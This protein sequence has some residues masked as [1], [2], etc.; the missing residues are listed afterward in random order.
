MQGHWCSSEKNYLTVVTKNDYIYCLNTTGTV[1]FTCRLMWTVGNLNKFYL[2]MQIFL[3]FVNT[4]LKLT[5]KCEN[6]DQNVQRAS[7]RN[8]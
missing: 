8:S 4:V 7:K 6:V 5:S 1:T 2:Q 3:P